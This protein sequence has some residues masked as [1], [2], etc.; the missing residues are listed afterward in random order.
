M[1]NIS[2]VICATLTPFISD[3]GL[4][5]Y[6]WIPAHLRFLESHGIHG[7]L[8][9]GTTGEGPSLG[10]SERQRVL[11][12]VLS[13]RG[14]LAVI[15]GT[16]CAALAE[17]VTLSQYALDHGADA[18]LVMPPFYFKNGRPE[19]VLNYY[20]ALCDAL[21]REARLLLYH[22]PAVTAVPITPLVIE[23]L[24]ASHA[25]QFYGIKDSSGDIQHTMNLIQRY[26]QLQIF[27]GSDTQV[28][29]ALTA[30]AAGVISA[31][32]N[33]WPN[34]VRAVFDAHQH[35]RDVATPQARLAA[36]RALIPNPTPPPLKA[37]L[38]WRSDLPRTS[39]RV[40]L[41]NLSDDETAQLRIALE[42]IDVL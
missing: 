3:V 20:R 36:V 33:V 24:L 2:G 34:L 12:L 40:P 1:Q 11:D 38:P 32:S 41:T 21:P 19:G 7:V 9:L 37:V 28:A 6:E 18:I 30:N 23:G 15:A 29:N 10:L 27:S 35:G 14:G 22:I 5:D 4:V 26:P 25:H 8:A 31:L 39:V 13:H 16:G 42:V 17:T